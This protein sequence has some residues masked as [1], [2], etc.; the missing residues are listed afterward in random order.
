MVALE[1]SQ[2]D[3]IHTWKVC[4]EKVF[5]VRLPILSS[6]KYLYSNVHILNELNPPHSAL[7][8]KQYQFWLQPNL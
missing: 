3:K 6:S 1:V 4:V 8:D 7:L 2:K 5:F